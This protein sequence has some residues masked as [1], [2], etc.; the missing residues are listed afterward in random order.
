MD[1][2]HRCKEKMSKKNEEWVWVEGF[3]G[4]DFGM[5]C[6]DYVY[7]MH[8]QH[9]MPEGSEITDCV[10]GFHLCLTIKQVLTYYPL[11]NGNRY[12]RV[13]ALVRKSDLDE[14]DKDYID[15]PYMILNLTALSYVQ[16]PIKRDKLVAKS[17]VFTEE[18]TSDEILTG[19]GVDTS[20]WTEEQKD[21]ALVEGVA[22]IES[23]IEKEKAKK[24]AES[25]IEQLVLLGYSTPFAEYIVRNL[26]KYDVAFAVGSQSDLSMDTKIQ[27]IFKDE[28]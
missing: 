18:L 14:Y 22:N 28:M 3:K 17:I 26:D 6:R 21:R 10:S 20:E 15:S 4:T 13:K 25:E 8:E 16:S 5:K 24:K 19:I 23:E 2:I 11:Y 27:I 1:F 7:R 12:F 9:D